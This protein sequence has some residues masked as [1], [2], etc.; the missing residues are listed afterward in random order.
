MSLS[1]F[2]TLIF[3]GISFVILM[4][5]LYE[6]IYRKLVA[7]MQNR[8][9][10]PFF[11]PLFDFLKLINKENIIVGSSNITFC[12]I[13]AFASITTSSLFLPIYGESIISF[14]GDIFV[15]IYLLLST[16]V[17]FILTGYLSGSPF[18][19]VGSNRE[20]VLLLLYDFIISISIFMIGWKSEFMISNVPEKLFLSFPFLTAAFIVAT[21]AQLGM[22]PFNISEAE[23]EIVSGPLTECSGSTL[24]MFNLTKAIRLFVI[25]SLVTI[26]FFNHKNFFDFVLYSS[27]I[28]IIMTLLRVLTFRF[29]IDQV[30]RIYLFMFALALIDILK[31]VEII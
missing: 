25:V 8:I 31:M 3:P 11:Q 18:G 4:G 2:R 5:F 6:W 17:F 19:I 1:P 20:I 26:L 9:G 29:R 12:A 7:R 13:L 24:A 22:S 10:P 30:F 28:L 14:Y 16:S 23:Q 15:V 27:F 21:Q